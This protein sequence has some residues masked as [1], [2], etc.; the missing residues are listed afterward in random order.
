[1]SVG[2]RMKLKFIHLKELF[3]TRGIMSHCGLVLNYS[4]ELLPQ[5]IKFMHTRNYIIY[6]Y[7]MVSAQKVSAQKVFV[8]KVSR[9]GNMGQKKSTQKVSAQKKSQRKHICRRF[10]NRIR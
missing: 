7:M 4:L 5:M 8:H 3:A 2:N 10:F 9:N 6:I 1:M